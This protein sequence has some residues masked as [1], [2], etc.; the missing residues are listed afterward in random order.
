MD[1]RM[2]EAALR[3]LERLLAQRKR[4]LDEIEKKLDLTR[5]TN[6]RYNVD[7]SFDFEDFGL[8][9]VPRQETSKSVTIDRNSRF[10]VRSMEMNYGIVSAGATFNMGPAFMNRLFNFDFRVRDTG[11]DREWSND[12]LP[13][14]F[15]FSGDVQG[16]RFAD[17]HAVVSGNS[18]IEVDVRVNFSENAGTEGLFDDIEK[19]LLQISFVGLNL[20]EELSEVLE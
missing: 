5:A 18:D 17:N 7:F 8:V 13:S 4:K 6:K 11:S 9:S 12:W 15:L 16:L 3:R 19:H 10:M 1:E 2:D 14:A 20:P